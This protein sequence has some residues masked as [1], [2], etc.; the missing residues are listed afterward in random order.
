[1]GLFNEIMASAYVIL[2]RESKQSAHS[3]AA[4]GWSHGLEWLDGSSGSSGLG[5]IGVEEAAQNVFA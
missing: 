3:G 2:V 4:C 5:L 1:M